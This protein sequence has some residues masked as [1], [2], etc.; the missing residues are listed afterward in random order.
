MNFKVGNILF[1]VLL[2][3]I[4]LPSQNLNP[5]DGI[6]ITFYNITD[7]ISGDYYVQR[8]GVIQF[9]F[10]GVVDINRKDV[11]SIKSEIHDKYNSLYRNPELTV[12][13]LYKV[14]ILGEVRTPGFYYV[15]GF[16]KLSDLL[17]LAGGETADA[18]LN[19]IHIIR[20]N[21]EYIVDGEE[22]I[23]K[24]NRVSDI[25]LQSGDRVFVSRSWWVGAR[26]TT[27]II[28]GIAVLVTILS[29]FIN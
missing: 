6:R 12:Q 28:S 24:G 8:G 4:S 29:L 15:T 7:E 26:N 5:G 18:D 3:T 25:G 16:E 10:I 17:A 11:D 22:I 9:P 2:F 23:A 20:E 14:N 19:N 27:I 1:F 13:P 21:E